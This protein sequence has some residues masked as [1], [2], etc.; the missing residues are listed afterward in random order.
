[1]QFDEFGNLIPYK[2]IE[3]DLGTFEQKFVWNEHRK[4]LFDE[5]VNLIVELKN[6]G[7]NNFFQWING[8][9]VTQK[10]KPNDID[11]VTFIDFRLHEQ[12]HQALQDLKRKFENLDTYYVK[13][14]PQNHKLHKIYEIDRKEW[15]F[16]FSLS[17][18]DTRTGKS[19]SKGF[20]Q[21]N[22]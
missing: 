14:Y 2:I 15:I 3:I 17:R 13:I 4:M 8:S 11:I 10:E 20:V 22:F 12:K 1:M 6:L 21:I 5:Y 19:K 16:Q 7:I 9:F 18:K